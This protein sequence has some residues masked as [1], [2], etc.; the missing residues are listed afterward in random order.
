[1]ELS[2]DEVGPL[3]QPRVVETFQQKLG[4]LHSD[5][6]VAVVDRG[7][8]EVTDPGKVGVVVPND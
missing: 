5:G 1:V 6:E 8:G 2:V 3:W 4:G 7:E